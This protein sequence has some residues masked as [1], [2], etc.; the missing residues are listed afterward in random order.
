MRRAIAGSLDMPPIGINNI[1]GRGR[2]ESSIKLG[3]GQ[4]GPRPILPFRGSVG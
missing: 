2:P 4:S 1:G 3:G